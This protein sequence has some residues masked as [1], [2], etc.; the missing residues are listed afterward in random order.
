MA[1]HTTL[2]A[3]LRKEL[4]GVPVKLT[5]ASVKEAAQFVKET[6]TSVFKGYKV[7]VRTDDDVIIGLTLSSAGNYHEIDILL[8]PNGS[9][10]WDLRHLGPYAFDEFY[11]PDYQADFSNI[12]GLEK[13]ATQIVK[14]GD[15]YSAKLLEASKKAADL[16]L[17]VKTFMTKVTE[18][19]K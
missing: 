6:A 14:W 15:N 4:A 8:Q 9:I 2:A 16:A 19:T 3:A 1:H 5:A 18:A 17:M 13:Y 10:S 12:K 11:E 7:S